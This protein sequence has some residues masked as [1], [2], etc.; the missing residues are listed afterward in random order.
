MKFYKNRKFLKIFDFY[1][2]S[3]AGLGVLWVFQALFSKID[4][5]FENFRMFFIPLSFSRVKNSLTYWKLKTSG[6]DYK[7]YTID[8]FGD[9]VLY[10]PSLCC[11]KWSNSRLLDPKL[12]TSKTIRYHIPVQNILFINSRKT[13]AG[14]KRKTTNWKLVW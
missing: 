1:K 10:C 3:F 6:P 14:R 9:L 13:S 8:L 11:R 2:T 4:E 5:K 12:E 7:R